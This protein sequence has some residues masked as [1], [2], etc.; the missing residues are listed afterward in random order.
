MTTI[1]PSA[2][3]WQLATGHFLPRCLHVVA[4][5]GVADH[6]GDTPATAE[7]LA[8]AAGAN[9]DALERMLRLLAVAGIFE[10]RGTSWAHTELSRLLRSDHPQSMRPF[11]RMIGGRMQWTAAGELEYA[12]RTGDAAIE[13]LVS[14]GL[15]AYFHDHPEEARIFDAA[16][17][18]KA[19]AEI[20]ALLPAFDF[21]RYGVIADVGGGRGHV[22]RA[23]LDAA[24]GAQGVLFDQPSVVGAL[25]PSPRMTFRGGD[26]FKDPLPEADAY[27][28]S[29]VL[30]DWADREAERILRAVRRSAPRHAEVLV[31]ES[32]L[33]EGGEAHHAK[34]LDIVMLALT[35][36][37]ERTQREYQA[38]FEA[39]GFRLDR[40]AA[41]AGPF[42]VIV[43][44]PA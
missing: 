11:V 9:A 28:L 15:W 12:G 10:A 24:P 17:T 2:R 22:L 40:V 30:H 25:A 16:M 38:L 36:G 42:S 26:F 4:E 39:A 43:G 37:R 5:L 14:G 32:P 27:L 23:V 34:V 13:K 20:R 8:A 29:N 35:G 33:P 3:L 41:T 7:A 6:L 1:P 21:S 18:G 31:L 19:V 44:V